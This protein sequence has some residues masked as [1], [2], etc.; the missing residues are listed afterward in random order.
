MA[1][2]I[3]TPQSPIEDR[4][5]STG[6]VP[7]T[8]FISAS[9]ISRGTVSVAVRTRSEIELSPQVQ[10]ATSEFSGMSQGVWRG[11]YS[12]RGPLL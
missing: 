9:I 11:T 4:R 5:S 12:S 2:R 10:Q 6:A 3:D 1:S 8:A 7:E